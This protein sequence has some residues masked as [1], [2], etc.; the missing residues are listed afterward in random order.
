M[1]HGETLFFGE[2]PQYDFATI[3]PNMLEIYETYHKSEEKEN[4]LISLEKERKSNN[5][6]MSKISNISSN[7]SSS[8]SGNVAL[9]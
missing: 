6:T 8:G 4:L 5:S 9:N 7:I 3:Q 2:E 1:G